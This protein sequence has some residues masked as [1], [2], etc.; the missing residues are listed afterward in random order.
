LKTPAGVH[1]VHEG[2]DALPLVG[3]GLTMRTGTL[4]DPRGR[5]GMTRLMAQAMRM[6]TAGMSAHALQDELDGLGGQLSVSCGHGFTSLGGVVLAENAERFIELLAAVFARPAFR[7]ADVAQVKRETIG[8]LANLLDDDR[9]LAAL[10]F[11]RHAFGRHPFGRSTAGT[12]ATVRAMRR[13]DLVRQH[14]RG[15]ST[16][17]LV[18]SVWGALGAR[19]AARMLDRHLGKLSKRA[20]AAPRLPAPRIGRGRRLLL[21]DKPERTQ[22]QIF[23][24]T[25]GVHP[26]ERVYPALAVANTVFGGL[27]TSRLMK[28]VRSE[29][30]W[31]YGASS[32]FSHNVAADLWSMWTFPAASDARACIE[33][34]LGLY[35]TWVRDGVSARELKVAKDYI[36]KGHAF[37][38]DTARKR[39]DLKL[40]EILL[41]LPKHMREKFLV[42][43]RKVTRDEV[44]RALRRLSLDDLALTVVG[45][46]SELLPELRAM[47]GIDRIDVVPYD[48]L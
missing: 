29:R 22:T 28:E 7:A 10:H 18:A 23:V 26:S 19:D 6:G 11:R 21:V 9:S 15:L 42:R 3:V 46:A 38:V 39:I 34:Q 25:L 45:T 33:L 30:G 44:N 2:S 12:P 14:R 43:V 4:S 35:E 1:L 40:D 8:R 24:G 5:E 31:S 27:F 17:N 16:P 48:A 36:V 13:D 47:Q 32:H 41:H 37:D 20:V